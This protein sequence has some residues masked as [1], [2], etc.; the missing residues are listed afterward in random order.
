MKFIKYLFLLVFLSSCIA[1]KDVVL[2][3]GDASLKNYNIPHKTFK[4]QVNDFLFV[5]IKSKNPE[6]LAF[7]NDLTNG[8]QNGNSQSIDP[9]MQGLRIDPHGNIRLPYI[10]EMNVLGY[11]TDE[12]RVM[13]E[14]KL[15]TLIIDKNSYFVDVKLGGIKYTVL[16]EVGSP[17]SITHL[18][19]ETNIVE[20]ISKAGDFTT[21]ANRKKVEV[22]RQEE[23]GIK[24][25]EID[26]T[27]LEALNSE[28]FLIKA[29]DIINVKPLKQ[30]PIGIGT[31][32]LSVFN[33]VISTFSVIVTTV[34][35]IKT[36]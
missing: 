34:L 28:V 19:Y 18:T 25:Y 24:K 3:Q 31:T 7:F 2:L 26:V 14:Q 17:G 1:N 10:G 15:S 32:G 8:N 35:F 20:A 13:I 27:N 6:L 12:I 36:L 11:T 29:N 16:G 5:T 23:N 21:Y 30:K 22:I 9:Y 4:T 33:T